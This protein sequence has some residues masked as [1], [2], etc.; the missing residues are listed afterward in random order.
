MNGNQSECPIVLF[1][2]FFS[3]SLKWPLPS[4]QAESERP[5]HFPL[6]ASS[7]IEPL[8]R[9]LRLKKG[10][11]ARTERNAT[12]SANPV[13]WANHK[14]D[15]NL[16]SLPPLSLPI[17]CPFNNLRERGTP[18]GC[19]WDV[20]AIQILGFL[21]ASFLNKRQELR[22]GA[23]GSLELQWPWHP[24]IP[25]SAAFICFRSKRGKSKDGGGFL[26]YLEADGESELWWVHEG[27]W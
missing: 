5:S 17:P 21:P 18:E 3:H 25:L 7:L 8:Q 14:E 15:W 26:C 12:Y 11:A 13:A 20:F 10:C 24:E 22:W 4:F 16:P 1:F 9:F 23:K 2:F 19:V 6:P 27:A